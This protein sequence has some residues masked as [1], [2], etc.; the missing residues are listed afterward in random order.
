V[1]VVTL[2]SPYGSCP[3]HP[4]KYVFYLSRHGD[5]DTQCMVV[6]FARRYSARRFLDVLLETDGV[7]WEEDGCTLRSETGVVV[8][9]RWWP[10]R[11]RE[12]Y[13]HKY[14]LEEL[15]WIMD[16][17]HVG[18]A[19]KFRY[20]PDLPRTLE[21]DAGA[22]QSSERRAKRTASTPRTSR[23]GLVPIADVALALGIEPRDARACL[24]RLKIE[25]PSSGWAFTAEQAEDIKRR[26]SEALK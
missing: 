18:Y 13:D 26:I 7:V 5:D 2:S 12:C 24:R 16:P 20:G 10:G 14:S 6:S 17:T 11:L 1:R 8:S 3:G 19:R 25:K 22:Q 15:G 23:D 4:A 21:E 9:T